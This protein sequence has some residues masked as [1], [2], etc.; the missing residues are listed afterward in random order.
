MSHGGK[1]CFGFG[2]NP[3]EEHEYSESA[4]VKSCGIACALRAAFILRWTSVRKF[5]M[6]LSVAE[7]NASKA[8]GSAAAKP[9]SL[10]AIDIARRS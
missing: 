1:D 7:R 2:S 3:L 5:V 9:T 6:Y 10:R 4:L 8:T